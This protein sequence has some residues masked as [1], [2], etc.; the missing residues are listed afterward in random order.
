MGGGAALCLLAPSAQG[1]DAELGR[2]LSS[3]CTTCH[4][5]SKSDS[6][7]PI[8]HGLGEVHF[9]EVIKAYRDKALPNPVMQNIAARL[10]DEEIAALA[11]YFATAK[12]PK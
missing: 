3:E 4:G 5:A 9:V 8:I 2:Y 10:G 12:K 11:A 6:T 1:A 7:I